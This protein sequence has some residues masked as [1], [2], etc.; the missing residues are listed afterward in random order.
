[1]LAARLAPLHKYAS[2]RLKEVW[3]QHHRHADGRDT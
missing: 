1:M 3:R 2:D